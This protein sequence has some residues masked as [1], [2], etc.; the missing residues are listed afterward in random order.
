MA[1]PRDMGHHSC[2]PQPIWSFTPIVAD[3]RLVFPTNRSRFGIDHRPQPSKT[4]CLT[5]RSTE[6]L[7]AVTS[8]A[9]SLRS[10][11]SSRQRSGAGDRGRSPTKYSFL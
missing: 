10:R 5:E 7:P 11:H 9:W 8:S 4:K 3:S 2:R 6:H 1:R